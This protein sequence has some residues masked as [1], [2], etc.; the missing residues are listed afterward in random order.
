V[1]GME[2]DQI[3]FFRGSPF[4]LV[5]AP[6]K[7]VVVALAALFAVATLDSVFLFHDASDFAPF[8]DFSDFEDLFE[9]LVFL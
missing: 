7:V 1:L 8:L 9:D 6:L 4:L 5:Y 2:M 3:I